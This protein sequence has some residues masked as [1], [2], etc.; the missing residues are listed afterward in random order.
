MRDRSRRPSQGERDLSR[1]RRIVFGDVGRIDGHVPSIS[2][3]LIS[4]PAEGV[5]RP[6][7][8]V[9]MRDGGSIGELVPRVK[10]DEFRVLLENLC[11]SEILSCRLDHAKPLSQTHAEGGK[12][13]GYNQY[14]H[15]HL[16]Q[17]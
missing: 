4:S 15:H 3:A 11:G 16:K 8:S 17:S 13:D 9:R 12:H 7:F 5:K 10:A 2:D 1:I 6:G 14:P